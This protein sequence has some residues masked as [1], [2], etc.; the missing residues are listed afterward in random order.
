MAKSSLTDRRSG[1]TVSSNGSAA[2][3]HF[4]GVFAQ[5]QREMEEEETV[6]IA[7]LRA[8]GV[9]AAHP[10]DGWV[11]RKGNTVHFAYPQFNDGAGVGDRIA[12]GNAE[13]YR[14]VTLTGQAG[15]VLFNRWTFK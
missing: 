5:C 1:I 4:L 15:S 11:D 12:L 7:K 9:K 10:D 13:E 6:W 14:I 3:N 8:E 2:G